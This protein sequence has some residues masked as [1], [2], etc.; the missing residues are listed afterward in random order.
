MKESA[1]PLRVL[2]MNRGEKFPKKHGDW[3]RLNVW[4]DYY[5][6]LDTWNGAIDV[7][8]G[9]CKDSGTENMYRVVYAFS[10]KIGYL[11]KSMIGFWY[12]HIQ[13]LVK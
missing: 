11:T 2:I 4:G 12:S 5:L 9:E 13:S 7:H 3:Y 1:N 8:K 6:V 10:D